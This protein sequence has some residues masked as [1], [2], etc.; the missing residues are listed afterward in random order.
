MYYGSQDLAASNTLPGYTP[1]ASNTLSPS[2][3]KGDTLL[4]AYFATAQH[5]AEGV[6]SNTVAVANM[7][8]TAVSETATGTRTLWT[9][10]AESN[11]PLAFTAGF[12][13]PAV[14]GT[15]DLAVSLSD[16]LNIPGRVNEEYSGYSG[17]GLSAPLSTVLCR[18]IL[19]TIAVILT[20]HQNVCGTISVKADTNAFSQL[21]SEFAE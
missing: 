19:G 12:F 13:L 2:E 1:A 16:G 14:N 9:E 7:I 11:S 4:G 3:S 6:W 10:Y 17:T 20:Q 8:E 18:R 21:W 5:Y 15:T